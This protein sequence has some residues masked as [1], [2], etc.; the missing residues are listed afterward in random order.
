M[1]RISAKA[2]EELKTL[3]AR[4]GRPGQGVRV[5]VQGYG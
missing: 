3:M 2:A 1:V 5:L 4:H